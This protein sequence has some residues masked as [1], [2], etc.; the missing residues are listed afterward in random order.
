MV[1]RDRLINEFLELVRIDSLTLK[2]RE[3]A[4]NLKAKLENMGLE[5][6]EDDAGAKIGGN[7][8]NIIAT[9]K[10]EQGIPTVMLVAHMD[11]VPP[12]T[13]KNPIV[14]GDVIKTDGKTVLGGDDAAG[15]AC[16]LESLK[17]IK[18]NNIPHGDI[19]VVFTVAEEG[20]LLG[21]KNLDYSKIYA[22]YAFVMD[23]GGEIGTVAVKAPSQNKID[24]IVRG[25]A[26]HAGVEPEKG[27]S[28]IQIAAKAI[29][30]MKLGRIDE[31]TTA[32][33][34]VINGGSATNIVCDK[35]E[36]KAECRSRNQAKLEKQTLHMEECFNKAALE[37]GGK[38]EFSYSQEYPAFSIN[39]GDPIISILKK[40][41]EASGI[42]LKLEATGGGSDT[43][44]INGKGIP[45]VDLSV[46]MDK[47]HSVDEQ[48]KIDDMVKASEFLVH[49]LN[50][51]E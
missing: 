47:I 40:A 10:G 39:D 22:K 23:D 17:I 11:T 43:N 32:N 46:G 18:E 27:V 35:V 34:G 4:D 16:I 15:I 38:V 7:A 19:Q 25:K 8:G 36:I 48:I 30:D 21:S 49:V 12:G 2:E 6:Y 45:A 31:E 9:L 20:G 37:F 5:V 44:I 42:P 41:S 29:S 50:S 24:V 13:G 3:M 1:N 28:A 26:A 51:V 14:E 33:I